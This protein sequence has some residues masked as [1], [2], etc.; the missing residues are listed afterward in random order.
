MPESA[1]IPARN[2]QHRLKS[3]NIP[4][5]GG[6][7]LMNNLYE[8]A[9]VDE[10]KQR[11]A[12]LTS[13]SQRQWGTMTASQAL[14]HCSAAMEMAT[15]D[16]MPPRMLIGRLI[17]GMIRNK[18]LKN[19]DPL[20]R[21]TPTAKNLVISDDRDLAK[22][23]QRLCELIDRFAKVGPNGCTK[24]PHTFFGPMT[25]EEWAALMYKHLDHHLRQFGA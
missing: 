15:G 9:R 5:D 18:V 23:Q 20:R 19:S 13:A 6:T 10:V 1:T 24:H 11:V 8:P 21:N 16:S 14:A 3:L 25:P 17:G 7:E 22:E 4:K 12:T 2:R